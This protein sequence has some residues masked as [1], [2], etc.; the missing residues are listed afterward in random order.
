MLVLTRLQMEQMRLSVTHAYPDEG[1]GALLGRI[2]EQRRIVADLVPLEN[3]RRGEAA[4]TRF[5]VTSEDYRDL[6]RKARARKLDILGFYH[7]HPDHP[8]RPSEYDREHALPWYTYVILRVVRGRPENVT[9][10][11]LRDD[12]SAFDPEEMI[13]LDE[14]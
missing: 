9:S 5:L 8:A 14:R 4:R 1:C 3:R 12:R 7:S 6:E 13:V 10:W 11:I 2:E